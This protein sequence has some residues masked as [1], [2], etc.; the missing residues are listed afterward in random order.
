MG[1]ELCKHFCVCVRVL[2]ILQRHIFTLLLCRAVHGYFSD[3]QCVLWDLPHV[4]LLI[5]YSQSKC[6]TEMVGFGGI[7]GPEEGEVG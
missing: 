4:W 2:R 6:W 3:V 7:P 1:K 5:L